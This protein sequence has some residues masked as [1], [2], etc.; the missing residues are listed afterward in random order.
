MVRIFGMSH[1]KGLYQLEGKVTT[2]LLQ[3][4]SLEMNMR[5][6]LPHSSYLIAKAYGKRKVAK[7]EALT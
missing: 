3:F 5:I 7:L 4:T 1:K 2:Q 6:T